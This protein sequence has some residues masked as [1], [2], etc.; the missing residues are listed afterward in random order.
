LRTYR[1]KNPLLIHADYV[2]LRSTNPHNDSGLYHN[3]ANHTAFLEHL[4]K[5]DLE[6]FIKFANDIT[7]KIIFGSPKKSHEI[8]NVFQN[9]FE[10]YYK[11]QGSSIQIDG[12]K[13]ILNLS[14]SIPKKNIELDENTVVGVDMGV[15]I[16]AMCALNKNTYARKRIGSKEDF[17]RVR[18]KIQS[19]R[20]RLQANLKYSNGGHGRNKKM[21]ALSKFEHYESNFVKSYNHMVSK[22]VVNFAVKNRAKYI[23]VEDL[24]GYDSSKFILRNWSYYQ[25]QQFITYKANMYGIEVRK[26]KP[27]YTSQRCSCCGYEDPGNRPKEEKGQA[28]FKCLQCGSEMNADFNAARNIAMSTEWSEDESSCTKKEKTKNK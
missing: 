21:R 27:H 19:Q 6:V 1:D 7:F 3:Y 2:R 14:I 13:I 26:I 25:L 16:P 24:T 4:Y 15:A 23:N 9:I 22:E 28:Y 8:R 20:K 18:T 10:E 12:T 11:I 17:L 5:N